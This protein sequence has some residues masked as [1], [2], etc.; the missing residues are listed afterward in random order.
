MADDRVPDKADNSAQS[1]KDKIRKRKRVDGQR[2]SISVS[3]PENSLLVVQG[4]TNVAG[5]IIY[6]SGYNRV[7]LESLIRKKHRHASKSKEKR[8]L[9]EDEISQRES[10]MAQARVAATEE[11]WRRRENELGYKL[12]DPEHIELD[13]KEKEL[14]VSKVEE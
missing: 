7:K 10:E 11:K 14:L 4:N 1:D 5:N 8:L 9:T 3:V 6:Q 2:T 12:T 13:R